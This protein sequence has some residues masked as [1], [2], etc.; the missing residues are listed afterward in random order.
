MMRRFWF[1]LTKPRHLAII[2]LVASIAACFLGVQLLELALYWALLATLLLLL[3]AGLIGLWR[4]R[5]AAREAGQL[6]TAIGDA[7]GTQET[8]QSEPVG[9]EVRQ[10]RAALLKA[11]ATIRSSRLGAVAGHRAL[12]ELPWYLVIGNPAAGKSTAI[13]N[14]GLQFPFAEGKVLQGV[15]GTRQC[16]WF[17]TSEGIL[18]DTAGRYSVQDEHRPEWYGFLDL[19]RKHRQRAPINGILIAVSIAEQRVADF[20]A[21]ILLAR[22]L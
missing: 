2:G 7:G 8:Q 17:F 3:L 16:D 15:G 14:S 22:S 12:Y 20:E 13:A 6:A 21:G 11:I 10:L 5:R 9:A 4:R 1:Y 18:L 19:L